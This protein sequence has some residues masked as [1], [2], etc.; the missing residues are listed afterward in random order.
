MSNDNMEF[1]PEEQQ[2]LDILN[3]KNEVYDNHVD[4]LGAWQSGW[5]EGWQEGA[6]EQTE[7]MVQKLLKL[8]VA[9]EIIASAADWDLAMVQDV[10]AA[11]AKEKADV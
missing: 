9:P 4:P 10:Q 7:K 2:V 11:L 5:S 8:G 1:S 6:R 3:R